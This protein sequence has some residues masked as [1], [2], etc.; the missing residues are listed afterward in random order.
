MPFIVSAG[1][2]YFVAFVDGDLQIID[3]ATRTLSIAGSGIDVTHAFT[4]NDFSAP[5]L[6]QIQFTQSAD[7]MW[8]TN[9]NCIPQKLKRTAPGTFVLEPYDYSA[10]YPADTQ[11]VKR[12]PFR[13]ANDTATTLTP[14]ATTGSVTITSSDSTQVFVVGQYFKINDAGGPMTGAVKVTLG[15]T[16]SCTADVINT[17]PDTGAYDDWEESAWS[18]LRGWPTAVTFFESRLVYGGNQA[19]PDSGWAS[20]VDNFDHLMARRFLQ[21]SA[22]DVSG[23]DFFG[24]VINSDPFSFT[25]ASQQVNAIAWLTGDKT[26]VAGTFGAEY[27]ISGPD[28]SQ[29]LGPLNVG[30]FSQTSYGSIPVRPVRVAN[31]LVFIQKGGR[32]IREFSFDLYEQSYKAD[33]IND[34]AE[35]MIRKVSDQR[36]IDPALYGNLAIKEVHWMQRSYGL[37]WCLDTNG[38]LFACTRDREKDI[39]A[40]HSHPLGGSFTPFGGTVAEPPL[41][42]SI[43]VL[44]NI[45]GFGDDLWL[46]VTRKINGAF[47][48]TIEVIS[49][50]W[51]QVAWDPTGEFPFYS[52]CSVL[53]GDGTDQTVFSGIDHLEGETVSVLA[54]GNP[55][56][57]LVVTAGAITLPATAKYVVVGLQMSA[58]V[59]PLRPEA[60]SVLGSAQG[61]TKRTDR[62]LVRFYRTIAATF[63]WDET[64]LDDFEIRDINTVAMG[65]PTPPF[66]GDQIVDFPGGY[67]TDGS[68]F[69]KNDKPV[70]MN[71]VCIVDRGVL[72]E[73]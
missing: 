4:Y 41:V 47:I 65:D 70:P 57:P 16:G 40:W 63:G 45:Q 54:D 20:L 8:L 24:P 67:D 12:I 73:V 29:G 52:D 68:L 60:G 27:I 15:G 35:H 11:L 66:T 33:E 23:L 42:R 59:K 51:E 58:V 19:Q 14:S 55:L 36:K 48:T 69:I 71:L 43:C 53:L 18:S 32:V 2:A 5:F 6:E 10:T 28:T 22:T 38:G 62:L 13:D 21:D 44:P 9:P 39:S 46:A 30:V 49:K 64:A 25:L 37:L 1:E 72:Y 34:H 3:A 56:D 17:L 31:A 61:G 26:L 7:I 50:E